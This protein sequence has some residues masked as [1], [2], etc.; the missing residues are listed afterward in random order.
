MKNESC[1]IF[2]ECQRVFVLESHLSIHL[3]ICKQS[4]KLTKDV[5][6]L[7]MEEF[8]KEINYIIKLPKINNND[9]NYYNDKVKD[10]EPTKEWIQQ[11]IEWKRSNDRTYSKNNKNDEMDPIITQHLNGLKNGKETIID[12]ELSTNGDM[13]HN[14]NKNE[15]IYEPMIKRSKVT[16]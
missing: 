1:M 6:K 3:K 4:M 2:I 16:I 11:Q 7:N 13:E 9:N 15:E 10:T 12:S 8:L 5:K 14:N